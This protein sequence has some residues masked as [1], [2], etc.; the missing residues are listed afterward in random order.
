MSARVI[1]P[2]MY[3][4]ATFIFNFLTFVSQTKRLAGVEC[5]G[6][7]AVRHDWVSC[8]VYCSEKGFNDGLKLIHYPIDGNLRFLVGIF[9]ENNEILNQKKRFLLEKCL[10][11]KKLYRTR[12]MR[13]KI[14]ELFCTYRK[15]NSCY[16]RRMKRRRHGLGK[17]LKT[18]K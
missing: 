11:C 3:L 4:L 2:L 8:N 15:K 17:L 9:F 16:K 14:G 12:I 5:Q 13:E 1:V 10:I 18:Q 7:T 6:I